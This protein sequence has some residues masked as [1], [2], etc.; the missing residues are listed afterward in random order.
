[1]T[2][3]IDDSIQ[4]LK[5]EIIAQDWRLPERRIEPL[6]DAFSCLKNRYKTRK[7]LHAIL[8]MADSVLKYLKKQKDNADPAF[9]DFLKETMAHVVSMYEEPKFDPDKEKDVFDRVYSQFGR[10]KEK[11]K[12]APKDKNAETPVSAPEQS[13]ISSPSGS[14][15]DTQRGSS[16]ASQ[17]DTAAKPNKLQQN[18]ETIAPSQGVVGQ[19]EKAKDCPIM[20]LREVFIGG[21]P[22]AIEESSIALIRSLS[23]K[24]R[25]NYLKTNHIPLKD[26]SRF[27]RNLSSEMKGELSAIK[28][29]KLKKLNLPLM[30]P[31]GIG[32]LSIPDENATNLIVLSHG[33]W[34][35]V[36]FC[37]NI[38]NEVRTMVKFKKAKNGDI[39][40]IGFV[41]NDREIPL[42]NSVSLVTREGFL[43]MV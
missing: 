31:G 42:L 39:A 9:L 8:T 2:L 28:N 32:L 5:T 19:Q 23:E 22:L 15:D 37:S 26:L 25:K 27:M 7:N 18:T 35:G 10:L 13:S 36:I 21:S 33:Q 16:P 12:A 20:E 24:K 17:K 4:K 11:V 30:V 6:E 38:A 29:S 14:I 40:G 1:M 34:H 43:A 41:E 3:S